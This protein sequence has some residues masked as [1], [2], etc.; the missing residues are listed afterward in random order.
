MYDW[1]CKLVLEC[2]A[3]F[4]HEEADVS[5]EKLVWRPPLLAVGYIGSRIGD[6]ARGDW[7]RQ[8]WFAAV[9]EES[10]FVAVV[11]APPLPEAAEEDDDGHQDDRTADGTPDDDADRSTAV[12]VERVPA[13]IP[14]AVDVVRLLAEVVLVLGA[15]PSQRSWKRHYTI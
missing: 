3:V 12:S 13:A 7:V 4:F 14:E 9:V 2:R 10:W 1:H 15:F 6:S 8:R 11:T 5:V